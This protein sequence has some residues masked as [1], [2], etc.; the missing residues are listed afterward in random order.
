[1]SAGPSPASVRADILLLD[2]HALVWLMEGNER[3]HPSV[4]QQI[5]NAAIESRVLVSAITPW[6]I[7]ILVSKRRL[8]LA[9][10][11]QLWIDAALGLPG[12]SLYPLLPEIAVSSTR[13]PWE[14]HP[15][16]ADRILVATARHIGATLVTADEQLLRYHAQGF[17]RCLS[18]V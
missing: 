18:A 14:M 2:T 15:D 8:N 7:A 11:V 17:L 16:P 3:L 4:R 9:K 12:V 5:E 10:E 1:M 6:E 13:L